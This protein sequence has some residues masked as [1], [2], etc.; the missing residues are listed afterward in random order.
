MLRAFARRR[1]LF[2]KESLAQLATLA[3]HALNVFDAVVRESL[4][5]ARGQV[6]PPN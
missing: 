4:D 3:Q 1:Q 6:W 2:G 5:D